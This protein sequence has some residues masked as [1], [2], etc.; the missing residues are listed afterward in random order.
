MFDNDKDKNKDIDKDKDNNTRTDKIHPVSSITRI[1]TKT[2]IK[3]RTK[4][5][6]PDTI[7]PWSC[8]KNKEK[9]KDTKEGQRQHH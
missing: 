3:T 8:D 7:H 6:R 5:I 4:D 9:N 2:R 1:K